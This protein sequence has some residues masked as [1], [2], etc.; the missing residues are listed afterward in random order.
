MI[1][2]NNIDTRLDE[3]VISE[4]LSIYGTLTSGGDLLIKGVVGGNTVAGEHSVTIHGEGRV[5]GHVFG[6]TI[7]VEGRLRGNLYADER[8]I[9]RA[10]ADVRGNIFSPRVSLQE[11]G[12]YKGRINMDS[13]A[14]RAAMART[15]ARKDEGPV[16][17]DS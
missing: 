7:I 16:F 10:S 13:K 3:S 11:G 9:L 14:R 4:C 17:E 8:V 15:R 1:M 12:I 2:E 6:R 5:N